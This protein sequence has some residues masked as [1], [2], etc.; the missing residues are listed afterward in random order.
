MPIIFE[1][2]IKKAG[3]N[4]SNPS[5]PQKEIKG[6]IYIL[7]S[8]DVEKSSEEFKVPSSSIKAK[9]IGSKLGLHNHIIA[10]YLNFEPLVKPK[11]PEKHLMFFV[12][13]YLS[14]ADDMENLMG[15]IS[16]KIPNSK[17]YACTKIENIDDKDLNELGKIIANEITFEIEKAYAQSTV[18]KISFFGHSMGGLIL[19]AA[20]EHLEEFKENFHCFFTLATPHLGYLH[21]KSKLLS[22]GMWVFSKVVKNPTIS[23]IRSIST[24]EELSKKKGMDWFKKVVF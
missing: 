13:G 11:L 15:I 23:Q 21:S 18:T 19:R 2:F 5:S 1:E 7:I 10:S 6:K 17:L 12:H 4:E 8:L 16:H 9:P 20:F 22:V 14:S 24:I 3:L